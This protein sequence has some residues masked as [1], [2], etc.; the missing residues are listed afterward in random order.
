MLGFRRF[1]LLHQAEALEGTVILAAEAVFGG[2]KALKGVAVMDGDG[3]EG[4]EL[5]GWD[6]DFGEVGVE[7]FLL[8]E[9]FDVI[10]GG[11]LGPDAA[12]APL[13]VDH[14]SYEVEFGLVGGFELTDVSF[15]ELGVEIEGFVVENDGGG[16][17]SVF[18]AVLGGT[19]FAG[20]CDG[21]AGVGSVAAGSFALGVSWVG[22]HKCYLGVRMA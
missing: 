5:C 20:V 19:G 10:H 18:E 14:L 21:A 4:E 17:E 16:T 8:A 22:G 9:D 3:F 11:F 6:V 15:A 2:F 13:G 12:E 1:V 7:T